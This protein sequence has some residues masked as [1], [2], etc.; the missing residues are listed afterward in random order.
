FSKSLFPA[1]RV[2]YLV[3]PFW[4]RNAI[5]IAKH[6]SD[7]NTSALA[8]DTLS[9]FM[10]EGHLGRHLRRMCKLYKERRDALTLALEQH[11]GDRLKVIPSAAGLHLSARLAPPHRAGVIAAKAAEQGIGLQPFERYATARMQT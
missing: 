7:A 6:L 2:G 9:A 1:L 5:T 3:C 8:Q 10:S 11:C 4:A